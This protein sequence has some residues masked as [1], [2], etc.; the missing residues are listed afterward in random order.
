MLTATLITLV[1]LLEL[2]LDSG[3]LTVALSA[4]FKKVLIMLGAY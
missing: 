4:L 2:L 3:T 1:P